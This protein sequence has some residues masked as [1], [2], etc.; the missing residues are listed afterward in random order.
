[1]APAVDCSAAV[2]LLGPCLCWDSGVDEVPEFD[3][4]GGVW[5]RC[6]WQSGEAI[7]G[8]DLCQWRP[9]DGDDALSGLL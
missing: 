1:M 4:E 6:G 8:A 2:E 3:G 9:G 5:L 7:L